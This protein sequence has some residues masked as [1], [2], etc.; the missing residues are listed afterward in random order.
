M[1]SHSRNRFRS[2]L[3]RLC[4]FLA[5]AQGGAPFA[6]AQSIPAERPRARPPSALTG[7][8]D[9]EKGE[10][11]L[12]RIKVPPAPVRS[13]AE[14]M[15]TFK[16][17]PGYRIELVA[18]EP[19]VHNPIFFEFDPDGRIWVVEYQGY[20][21]DVAGTGEGDPI[22]RI[23]VLEDTDA[24][25]RADKSTVFLDKLVMPRS[26]A[27]VKGGVLL[28]EPPKLWFCEDTD[29]DLR[30]D[31]KTAVG[32][33]GVAGNP[34]HTANGLRYGIDNWLHNADWPKRHRWLEGKLVEEDS[35]QRGQFGLTFD[36]TG[37]FLTCYENKALHGDLIPAE[38]LLRN[39]NFLKLF[40]RGGGDR[41]AFGVNVD[42]ATRAQEVFPIR[43]TP[44]VTL[45]ALELRDDGR[46]RTYTIAS[47][48]C[49]YD[50]HQFP[51]DARG[52]VFVPE[53]GGHL[54][55]RLV[56][57]PG[58][59][60]Q[61]AR[62]YPPEQEFLASTDERFRPVNARVGPDGALYLA[63]M[64][65][66]I[67]E[68][69][70][71]MVPWLTKQIQ[72][73]HLDE[74]ND[75]G[76]IWR[77][78]AENQ[79]IDRSAPKL[80]K[81]TSAD[82]VKTLAHPNG[83]HRL[84]AQRLLVERNDA[85]ALPTLR[86]AT[87]TANPLGQLHALWTLD[88]LGA[89]DLA[90]RL[91]AMDSADERVR[92]VAIR[93]CERD[94]SP[95]TLADLAKRTADA[96]QP[97]RLQLALTLGAFN[98]PQAPA[99][100]AELLARETHPLFRTAVLTGL[101]G[102]E[103]DFL[104]AWLRAHESEASSALPSLL[105]QC[106]LEE[107]QAARITALLD[108]FAQVPPKNA[109]L[110]NAL[111]EAFASTRPPQPFALAAEPRALTALLRDSEPKVAAT[112]QRALNS[113]TWPGAEATRTLTPGA[114]PLNPVQQRLVDGGRETYA[115]ICA[116]CHQPHGGGNAGVAP[117]LAGS[118]WV[119]GPPERLARV[120]LHGL[121]GPVE[122]SGQRWNLHMPGFG[123]LDL[124]TD[125]KIAGV[126]SYVRRAWGNTSAPVEPILIAAV[127]KETA[128]RT[129]PWRAEELGFQNS[130][131]SDTGAVKPAANG[132]LQL[133]AR[134]AT[135]YG[136]KLAYRPSLDVL[137]PWRV[138]DDVAGWIVEVPAGGSYD[139]FVTLAADDASAG[140]RFRVETEGSN[141]VG[142]VLSSG[143]YDRFHEVGAGRLTLHAGVNRI[144]MRPEG[145]LR[146]ELADVRALRLVPVR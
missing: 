65:H 21:R 129:F 66:G 34:Q 44:A 72:E 96:S 90:T 106:V 18:A 100:L 55:G 98:D 16:L 127:R 95:A 20:M 22:C 10:A 94:P 64:Y 107:A 145:P 42:L 56:L 80:T 87:Q 12:K 69:I 51:A 85:T 109:G 8:A 6:S 7:W 50:G 97:V 104:T 25:G 78:V 143:G 26:F 84:T 1:F 138:Q 62:F 132:E 39:R 60:P 58:I 116:A 115:M 112:A 76:R 52:N 13:A 128:G 19:L 101:A 9:W 139:V 59:A 122:I 14:E 131:D 79:P 123:S 63:D 75:L 31:R 81:A 32:T 57:P 5:V 30:S 4:A 67:I 3:T 17:A 11:L 35:I 41:S 27:F 23:V 48:V 103:L 73:R 114:L 46:L 45:G 133:P 126:L 136:Q 74:G 40:Q 135:T 110:R 53:S 124:M 92:A 134:L 36:E 130:A 83:W 82:L 43:V 102:R 88:G 71:F 86:D 105:A 113:F 140:D 33:M 61:A 68:H 137:A 108:T 15:K 38:Y 24:D 99:L 142:T 119:S 144:L 2:L 89:L 49:C 118:D 125:E 117:P 28:Q 70:I 146:Q 121:Y 77:I 93:L 37:R 91:A 54:L 29:G 47:G 120:V 141:A 111:L